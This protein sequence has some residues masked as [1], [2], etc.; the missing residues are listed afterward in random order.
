[1]IHIAPWTACEGLMRDAARVLPP[2]APLVLHG[3]FS[4]GG[5]HTAPS[6]EAFDRGLRAQDAAWGVR[7]LEAVERAAVNAGLTLDESRAPA[8][9]DRRRRR[10]PARARA[11]R[12]AR[13]PAQDERGRL[14]GVDARGHVGEIDQLG[15]GVSGLQVGDRV[16]DMTVIGGNADDR[17]LRADHVTRV[18]S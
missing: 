2:G 6:N 7:D 4:R 18:T 15:D 17:T 11:G 1:M 13:R 8:A 12:P 3:P 14:G 9:P 10:P 16:A 5:R